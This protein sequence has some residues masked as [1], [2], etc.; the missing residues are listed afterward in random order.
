MVALV[1]RIEWDQPLGADNCL[2]KFLLLFEQRGEP[3]GR[4]GNPLPVL[5]AQ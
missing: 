1:E 4:L 5:V 3:L 2:R